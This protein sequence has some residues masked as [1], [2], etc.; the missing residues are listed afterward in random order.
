M[1]TLHNKEAENISGQFNETSQSETQVF[2]PSQRGH[3]DNNSHVD[4]VVG[5][6]VSKKK[7]N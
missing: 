2:V 7:N 3:C 5:E 1:N 6:P 4:T